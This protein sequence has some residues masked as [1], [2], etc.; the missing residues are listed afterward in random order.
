MIC[1]VARLIILN[2]LNRKYIIMQ[3]SYQ[4]DKHFG[5]GQ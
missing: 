1:I 5:S 3:W 2:I 4:V